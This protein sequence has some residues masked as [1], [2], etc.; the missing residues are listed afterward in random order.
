MT[1]EEPI[2]PKMQDK[3]QSFRLQIVVVC[4]VL[5]EHVRANLEHA[6]QLTKHL[7]TEKVLA[8][9]LGVH[10]SYIND[11]LKSSLVSYDKWK[12][13]FVK[14]QDETF[15]GELLGAAVAIL[16]AMPPPA[17]RSDKVAF[18]VHPK[19]VKLVSN[20]IFRKLCFSLNYFCENFKYERNTLEL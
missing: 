12:K 1:I 18:S 7:I 10:D 13:F 14:D 20:R 6:V 3:I 5:L 19:K 11:T 17:L 9:M 16:G 8:M 4:P 2:S 15:V